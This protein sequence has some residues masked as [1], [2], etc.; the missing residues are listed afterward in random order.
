GGKGEGG[1][2]GGG[3][4]GGGGNHRGGAA[5][6]V[7]AL[8]V[9]RAPRQ[10][11]CCLGKEPEGARRTQRRVGLDAAR[12]AA[13]ILNPPA[14]PA[15]RRAAHR[16]G[17]VEPLQR[18]S[19]WFCGRLQSGQVSAADA[20][21]AGAVGGSPPHVGRGRRAQSFGVHSSNSLLKAS[22]SRC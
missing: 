20:H 4:G 8:L 11:F 14:R 3:G 1:G 15:Q 19:H 18:A 2:R 9:R 5:K 13:N 16:R 7:G 22:G 21:R 12:S 17:A 6:G 10:R